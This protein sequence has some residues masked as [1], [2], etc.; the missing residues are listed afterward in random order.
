MKPCIC[1]FSSR[2]LPLSHTSQHHLIHQTRLVAKK[3]Q[4]SP[5]PLMEKVNHTHSKDNKEEQMDQIR[6]RCGKE[7]CELTSSKRISDDI[8]P[9]ILNLYGSCATSHDFEIYAPH[10]SF[11]DPLMCAHG[12]KQI[13]SAFYAISKV[14]I[15]VL[16]HKST[17]CCDHFKLTGRINFLEL[18]RMIFRYISSNMCMNRK[19]T[20]T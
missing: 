10:A 5:S 18:F 9:H 16:F 11:E 19:E 2:L 12:V 1:S 4:E 7:A 20:M 6:E 13:K 17:L 3:M 14:I 8:M 15:L